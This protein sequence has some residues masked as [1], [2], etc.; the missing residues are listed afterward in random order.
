[1]HP[2]PSA[3]LRLCLPTRLLVCILSAAPGCHSAVIT[4]QPPLRWP[5]LLWPCDH[6]DDAHIQAVCLPLAVGDSAAA[7]TA[8]DAFAPDDPWRPQCAA[9][10]SLSAAAGLDLGTTHTVS[11]PS[12]PLSPSPSPSI[13]QPLR[14]LGDAALTTHLTQRQAHL[15]SA[16]RSLSLARSLLPP[17][18]ASA[19][20]HLNLLLATLHIARAL[21]ATTQA[22]AALDATIQALDSLSPL[23]PL[24]STLDAS[25]LTAALLDVAASCLTSAPTA[26]LPLALRALTLAATVSP[27]DPQPIA[28]LVEVSALSGDC[29]ALDA[30]SRRALTSATLPAAVRLWPSPLW[31]VL[32]L[33]ASP[34]TPLDL[35]LWPPSALP[36]VEAI[37]APL[38]R[39]LDPERIGWL[40]AAQAHRGQWPVVAMI[41]IACAV[42]RRARP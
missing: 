26:Q 9:F 11:S 23:L 40:S 14:A 29:A 7:F 35:S 13:T 28:T 16:L 34:H 25:P 32:M 38:Q 2:H 33:D 1:M 31:A 3:R 24:A 42:E 30:A 6:T 12:D 17:P 15:L 18:P 36:E 10:V 5:P 41:G 27:D 8:C 20:A 4:S 21:D 37:S 39:Q 22:P 19:S